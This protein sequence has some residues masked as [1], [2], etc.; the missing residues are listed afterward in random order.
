MIQARIDLSSKVQR[1]VTYLTLPSRTLEVT[2][3][4]VSLTPQ[5]RLLM[6]TFL[7]RMHHIDTQAFLWIYSTHGCHY[8]RFVRNCSRLGDGPL[9]FIIAVLLLILEP[10]FGQAFFLTA[11]LAFS[12]EVSSYLI[13]KNIIQRDRPQ[14]KIVGLKALICPSDKFSFPSGHTGAAFVFALLVGQFYNAF[15]IA[16]LIFATLV[17]LSR[18][19]LGVHYPG[20]ILAGSLLGI[21]ASKSALACFNYLQWI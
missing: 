3:N 19:L 7:Q 13:L 12:I 2:N 21:V 14:Q 16:A 8:H 10:Q 17:G 18:V 15:F 6:N 4:W 5:R 9:Y 1:I 20:D 11:L